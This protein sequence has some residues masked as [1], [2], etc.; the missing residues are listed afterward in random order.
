[1]LLSILLGAILYGLI[2]FLWY[3]PWGFGGVWLA[4]KQQSSAE[5]IE[6]AKQPG[7]IRKGLQG[8]VI[9][10]LL[11]SMAM[12]A[13]YMVLGRLGVG[14]FFGATLG[15]FV[16]TTVKK[17]SQWKAADQATRVLWRLQDGV[18]FVSLLTLALFVTWSLHTLY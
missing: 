8:I 5:A 14:V 4:A 2:Q 12:H 9:P 15:L 1:M 11:M 13:L 3:S 10:A 7:W 16:L 18:L 6:E 17:Y